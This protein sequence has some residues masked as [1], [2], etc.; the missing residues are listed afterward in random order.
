MV[1][2]VRTAVVT[3][4]PRPPVHVGAGSTT[5]TA[6]GPGPVIKPTRARPPG[7]RR[8]LHGH[9]LRSR[10][11]THPSHGPPILGHGKMSPIHAQS[12]GWGPSTTTD[13]SESRPAPHSSTAVGLP[14][15]PIIGPG[16]TRTQHPSSPHSGQARAAASLPG[17]PAH[18][19]PE[20]PETTW[21]SKA[22][23]VPDSF[24]RK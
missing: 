11:S 24:H 6:K 10:K 9:P 3:P 20:R 17:G 13:P 14:H 4:P 18:T 19:R 8:A 12:T 1:I 15:T 2:P 23:L 5:A 16:A 7:D 21:K 22:T